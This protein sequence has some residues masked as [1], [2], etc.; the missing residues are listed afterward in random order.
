[1]SWAAQLICNC[2]SVPVSGDGWSIETVSSELFEL[3][4]IAPPLLH[5]DSGFDVVFPLSV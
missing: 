4:T 5:Y 2:P 1:M 3:P